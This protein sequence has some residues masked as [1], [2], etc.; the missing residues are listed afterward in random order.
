MLEVVWSI[1]VPKGG[2]NKDEAEQTSHGCC[3]SWTA[4]LYANYLF[5][6]VQIHC[7]WYVFS[8]NHLVEFTFIG[9]YPEPYQSGECTGQKF[10]TVRVRR[11]SLKWIVVVTIQCKFV[12]SSKLGSD[13]KLTFFILYRLFNTSLYERYTLTQF[14]GTHDFRHPISVRIC[15]V[16]WV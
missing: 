5:A 4:V 1:T 7:D 13:W 16:C 9:S 15:S 8:C 11:N 6:K 10:P 3:L 2:S 12:S 14:S